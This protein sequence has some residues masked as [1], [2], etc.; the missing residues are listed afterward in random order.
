MASFI[1]IAGITGTL[2]GRI[3]SKADTAVATLQG[4]GYTGSLNEMERKDLLTKLSL[5]E[6]QYKSHAD[7][8]YAYYGTLGKTGTLADRK[9][10]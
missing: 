2:Q 8:E 6:P 1:E 10:S 7:L 4:L 3:V 9:H 5:T